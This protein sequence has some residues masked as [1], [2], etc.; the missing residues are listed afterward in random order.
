M[1]NLK[2]FY[3]KIK[4]T[5]FNFKFSPDR[6]KNSIKSSLPQW[7]ENQI[8][9]ELSFFSKTGV[10]IDAI[11]YTISECIKLKNKP[12]IV[13][14]IIKNNKILIKNYMPNKYHPRFIRLINFL[15]ACLNCFKCPNVDLL[16]A[17]DDSY[18]EKCWLEKTLAPMFVISKKNGNNKAVLFPHIEWISQNDQLLETIE[19]YNNKYP[20]EKKKLKAYWV[21]GSSGAQDKI[22]NNLR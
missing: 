18:D 6:L 8:E 17:I 16:Y 3:H 22:E 10:N 5:N 2:G 20:W 4:N 14:I 15:R 1:L 11:E 7:M 9:S 12:Q 21:G 13:R 19:Q